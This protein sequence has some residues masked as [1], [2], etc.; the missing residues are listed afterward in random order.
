M[1][2]LLIA[3]IFVAGTVFA[4]GCAEDDNAPSTADDTGTSTLTAPTPSSE[5]PPFAILEPLAAEVALAAGSLVLGSYYVLDLDSGL[6]QTIVPDTSQE[7]IDAQGGRAGIAVRW[8]PDGGLVVTNFNGET[9]LGALDGAISR[10]TA[11]VPTVTPVS[12]T[13]GGVSRDGQWQASVTA[14]D[15]PGVV[16]GSTGAGGDP[17]FKITSATLPL[18]SPAEA[19]M[20][21]VLTDVC[22]GP[23]ANTGF[24][25]ELFDA[26]TG[27]LSELSASPDE[28]IPGFIW[29]PDGRAIAADIIHA[30]G[31][32]AAGSRREI[33]LIDVRDGGGALAR[34]GH[35]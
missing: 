31:G 10:P 12:P 32:N 23:D 34:V 7:R 21:A 5:T 19:S 11:P 22:A 35:V 20:L 3:A 28:L 27:S 14:V 15:G 1:N 13:G 29:R 24:D 33:V 9:Y 30:P 2:K 17:L 26:A 16:V 25:L 4:V 18:W 8:A 6:V